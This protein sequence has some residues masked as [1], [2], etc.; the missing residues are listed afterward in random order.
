MG[1][2]VALIDKS[3]I[4]EK[5]I[6]HSL[7]YFGANIHRFE[8]LETFPR[9]QSFDLVFIDWDIKIDAEPLALKAKEY[10][11]QTPIV[12]LHRNSSDSELKA[13]PH[14]LKKPIDANQARELTIRLAPKVNQLKIHK[15]L[16]YPSSTPFD[17]IGD[18]GN[19]AVNLSEM[20]SPEPGQ[21]SSSATGPESSVSGQ[22]TG[23]DL[24]EMSAGKSEEI[25]GTIAEA[26]KSPASV[27]PAAPAEDKGFDLPE[28]PDGEAGEIVSAGAESVE[29]PASSV[30]PSMSSEDKGFDLPE[31]SE[32]EK[33]GEIL[34][35]GA[36]SLELTA[37]S[38]PQKS[39]E[40]KGFDLPEMPDGEDGEI[41]SAGAESR[42]PSPAS[43]LPVSSQDSGLDLTEAPKEE[44]EKP[45]S[46][47]SEKEPPV[48]SLKA[49][50][51][52]TSLDLTEA[53]KEEPAEQ[54]LSVDEDKLEKEPTPALPVGLKEAK[55]LES[56]NP[57]PQKENLTR[58]M[59]AISASASK[60][61]LPEESSPFD[62]SKEASG[63]ASS[64]IK[65]DPS[66]ASEQTIVE[67]TET[68][69][70]HI[71]S[72]KKVFS[73]DDDSQ[74]RNEERDLS[75][76]EQT[77]TQMPPTQ[78]ILEKDNLDLDESTQND[79]GPAALVNSTLEQPFLEEQ[80]L[81][82]SLRKHKTSFK[83]LIQDIMKESGH[84]IIQEAIVQNQRRLI[85]KILKEYSETMEFENTISEVLKEYGREAIGKLF[86]EN[87]RSII[88]KSIT[89]YTHSAHF[90]EFTET[91]LKTFIQESS[92]IRNQVKDI[93][94]QLL[95]KQAPL[96]A[97]NII[98]SEIEKL[99]EGSK[100][101]E[102]S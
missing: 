8:D 84:E 21:P 46:A 23:F 51:E 88:D 25:V 66:T 101:K 42:E 82:M 98:E 31:M 94:S 83:E 20:P 40:N 77:F 54:P 22:N 63:P 86:A 99:L 78:G 72:N 36:E 1:L 29:S 44:S 67:Q 13:F 30:S 71:P 100:K 10:I 81:E 69:Q 75:S 97:K 80:A 15:F 91:T 52:N 76:L 89:A 92:F 87:S 50:A 95:K 2:E 9:D 59:T 6:S 16:Q 53:P 58:T 61:S 19:L 49:S 39:E 41:V 74:R 64:E 5:M 37:S 26:G 70:A 3:E 93:F 65:A 17:N 32:G 73:E 85:E 57:S 18:Q 35:A 60:R 12:I 79:L 47:S 4:I 43:S 102:E 48:S 68:R 62:L 7:H 24:P 90:E 45:L 27:S 33:A 38:P 34:S 56:Q 14:Q 11:T 28:M 96:M 55:S